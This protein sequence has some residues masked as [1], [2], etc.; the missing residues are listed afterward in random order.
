MQP[1]KSLLDSWG[2]ISLK[3]S[4][5]VP[6]Y[7]SPTVLRIRNVVRIEL[8]DNL[9][10]RCGRQTSQQLFLV[11][12]PH[13]PLAKSALQSFVPSPLNCST[14]LRPP[15]CAHTC[16]VSCTELCQTISALT[17][18]NQL[19]PTALQW[20]GVGVGDSVWNC[21][22]LGWASSCICQAS[23]ASIPFSCTW[24]CHSSPPSP[25]CPCLVNF[26]YFDI[27]FFIEYGS[28]GVC[29]MWM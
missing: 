18:G 14:F 26:A 11:H 3:I 2:S 28:V 22:W 24:T 8:W 17:A 12:N 27:D 10:P 15:S 6:P 13:S 16:E 20:V 21:A 23:Q 19:V 9:K 1:I 25:T 4:M 7:W 5:R 29:V